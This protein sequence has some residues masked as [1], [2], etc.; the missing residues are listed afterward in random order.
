M[1]ANNNNNNNNGGLF[2]NNNN[3]GGGLFGN[4]NGNRNNNNQMRNMTLPD[5]ITVTIPA[6]PNLSP[7]PSMAD[8]QVPTTFMYLDGHRY[9][10]QFLNGLPH[11][12]G[13]IYFPHADKHLSIHWEGDFDNGKPEGAGVFTNENTDMV[14]QGRIQNG[15]AT[16]F[17]EL[18]WS[19]NSYEGAFID[20]SA[21]GKGKWTVANSGGD[22]ISGN[23]EHGRVHGKAVV[24]FSNGDCF[25]GN[26]INGNPSGAGK[27]LFGTQKV[28]M[29]RNFTAGGIERTNTRDLQSNTFEIKKKAKSK[30]KVH[31]NTYRHQMNTGNN[32]NPNTNIMGGILGNLGINST[33]KATKKSTRRAS[34]KSTKKTLK[35]NLR[36]ASK[37]ARAAPKIQKVVVRKTRKPRGPNKPFDE[38]YLDYHRTQ[39]HRRSTRTRGPVQL[40]NLFSED[41]TI[42]RTRST[43]KTWKQAQRFL[44]QGHV[45]TVN[46][47]ELADDEMAEDQVLQDQI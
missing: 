5:P 11:G 21:H 27:M 10:G 4:N 46:D 39:I 2:G 37:K 17:G 19:E 30:V 43:L 36:T 1:F 9:T 25:E 41:S 22:V 16:G 18:Q 26:Y 15:Q 28:V 24:S 45:N 29:N 20:G 7:I 14:F 6:L 42:R 31:S 34:R 38:S 12:K 47:A 40:D 13:T 44:A 8:I 32:R 33:K 3:N 23:F 35:S